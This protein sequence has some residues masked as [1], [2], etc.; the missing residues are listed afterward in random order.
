MRSKKARRGDESEV[1]I[2]PMIDIVFIMLIFFI[3]TASFTKES[4]VEVDRPDK[5]N[6]AQNTEKVSILVTIDENGQ[7]WVGGRPVDVRATRA[8]IETLRAENPEAGV[9]I[10]AD[11]ASKN[12][13]LVQV[14]DAARLAGVAQVS[15]I[16]QK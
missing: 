11:G 16:T 1:D 9:V 14:V 15:L 3:V 4:G 8:N 5:N 7:V 6:K 12:G 10:Q 2:T 13:L